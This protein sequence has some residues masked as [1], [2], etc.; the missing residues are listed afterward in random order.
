[1]GRSPVAIEAKT[2]NHPC[3][4]EILQP[5]NMVMTGGMVCHGFNHMFGYVWV[6]ATLEL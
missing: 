1:M 3:G 6:D 4:N 5:I 2:I